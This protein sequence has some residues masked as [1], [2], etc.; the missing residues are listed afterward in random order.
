MNDVLV[1]KSG[2]FGIESRNDGRVQGDWLCHDAT[3]KQFLLGGAKQPAL[4][5]IIGNR[6][7]STYVT[8]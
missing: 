1:V 7:T 2:V 4:K 5:Y 3:N 6:L 8:D